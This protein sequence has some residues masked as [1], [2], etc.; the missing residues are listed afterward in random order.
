V[1]IRVTSD[2]GTSL[3]L[4]ESLVRNVLRLVDWLPGFYLVG[5]AGVVVSERNRRLGDRVAGTT[6]VSA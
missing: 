2:D 1:N 4:G 3:A 5:I 6:V